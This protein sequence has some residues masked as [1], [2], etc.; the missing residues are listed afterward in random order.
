M[1]EGGYVNTLVP[2]HPDYASAM[3][4][5]TA[6]SDLL[7]LARDKLAHDDIEGAIESSRDAIRLASSAI[8][9]RD[10]YVSGSLE[11]T[12]DYIS[13][14]YP[15]VFPVGDWDRIEITASPRVTLYK[16]V[17]SAMGKIRPPDR[18]VA[19][20]AV[21]IADTFIRTARHELIS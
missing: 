19:E 13:K 14:K 12:E 20:E 3:V 5:L 4:A 7:A 9:Y 8:L 17:L 2:K 6:A 15:G 10:G 16:M 11:D 1:D 21:V 18:S